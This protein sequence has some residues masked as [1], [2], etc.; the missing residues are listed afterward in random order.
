MERTRLISVVDDDESV[1]ESLSGLVR[2]VGFA[3][4]EFPS[5]E[6]F[7]R[8]GNLA[9]TACLILDIR[10]PGM[11]GLELQDHLTASQVEIPII[12]ITAHTEDD[13]VRAR[14]LR[15]GASAYL[16]KPLSEEAVLDAIHG[17]LST[18]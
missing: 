5:A 15:G 13:E 6:E 14:A 10:M 8:S 11:T 1:R 4:A 18:G 17:A 2:A 3:V 12:F 9:K 16:L 7:L